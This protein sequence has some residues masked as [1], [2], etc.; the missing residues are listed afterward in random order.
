GRVAVLFATADAER[1]PEAL[2][3]EVDDPELLRDGADVAGDFYPLVA[4]DGGPFVHVDGAPPHY[5]VSASR[6]KPLHR[7]S[8]PSLRRVGVAYGAP[9]DSGEDAT[10]WHR[11]YVEA[12]VPEGTSLLVDAYASTSAERPAAWLAERDALLGAAA[13]AP[14][15][16]F[17]GYPHVIG[18][19]EDAPTGPLD[20]PVDEQ[21]I[22]GEHSPL[23]RV[24]RFAWSAS[25][26]ELPFHDGLLRDEQGALCEPVPGRTGLFVVLLQRAGV[27][28]R[29]VRGRYLHLRFGFHGNGRATPEIAAVRAWGAR[30]SYV[31]RYLPELYHETELG[32]DAASGQAAVL[33]SSLNPDRDTIEQVEA[34][35][36]PATAPDFLERFVST[37]ESV[38]TP[39]EDRIAAAW[40]LT[41]PRTVPAESLEWLAGWI[42]LAFA[43]E[44]DEVVRRRMLRAAP[45]LART[46][47]TIAGLRLALDIVTDGG[48]TRGEVVVVEDWR[49]RRTFATLLGVDLAD[50]ADPLLA[51]VVHSG[52]SVVGD[53][54]ILGEE[55]RAELMALF[56]VSTRTPAEQRAVLSFYRRTAWRVSVLVHR[57]LPA[58]VI[59]RVRDANARLVEAD[60]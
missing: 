12:D 39:L 23:T 5:A 15:T 24:P 27:V 25:R 6:T 11:L 16:D 54:L 46:R 4:W 32:P 53:T 21:R 28:T 30:F 60:R 9:L 8:L 33:G 3:Y 41:D 10:V 43:P 7:L 1:V 42:G 44:L 47:G 56:D 34:A 49:L 52:N 31:E 20:R 13:S 40:M 26:S 37:F 58:S 45:E 2:V 57:D 36:L 22:F 35:V 55:E 50:E 48:V 18:E 38:L 51:G 19:L 17:P 29:A 14:Y 59:G